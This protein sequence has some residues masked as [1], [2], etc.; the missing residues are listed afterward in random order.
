MRKLL[1]VLITIFLVCYIALVGWLYV[2]QRLLLYFPEKQIGDISEYNL[3]NSQEVFLTTTDTT[4][5]QAWYHLPSND[6]PMVIWF[7]GN[8]GNISTREEKFRE[9][10]D[11]GYGYIAP[12]WRG[13]GKSGNTPSMDGL[14]SD[15]YS[16]IEFLKNLGIK[17]ENTILIGESL[18]SGIAMKV[19]LE[20]NFKGIFLIAPYTSIADRAQEI[21]WYLPVK[22]LVLDN[23]STLDKVDK[24]NTPLLIVHGSKDDVMPPSHSNYIFQKANEPKKLILYEG[25]G[26]GNLDTREIFNEM[27]KFFNDPIGVSKV[28]KE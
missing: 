14:Y 3:S 13:F 26:H 20:N 10:L 9:L 4:R 18:G 15:A 22:Y 25:K 21:Y 7:H 27:D 11:M 19:A 5:I 23:F 16:T 8:S 2:N 17:P 24:I 28:V 6:K 12:S 1:K